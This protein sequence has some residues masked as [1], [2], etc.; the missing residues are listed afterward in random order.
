MPGVEGKVFLVDLLFTCDYMA[1][2][3]Y[4]Q[5]HTIVYIVHKVVKMMIRTLKISMMVML[6]K[7]KYENHGIDC[8]DNDGDVMMVLDCDEKKQPRRQ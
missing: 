7:H 1:H 8:N 5:T 2:S 6:T 4:V 3:N